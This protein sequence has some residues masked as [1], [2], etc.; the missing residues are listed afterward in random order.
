MTDTDTPSLS[1]SQGKGARTKPVWSTIAYYEVTIAPS[2]PVPHMHP[3]VPVCIS[4]LTLSMSIP[5]LQVTI[6]PPVPP[7]LSEATTTTE[8][9]FSSVTVLN[10]NSNSHSN[11]T[12][13]HTASQ[14]HAVEP[15][16]A[17]GLALPVT[18]THTPLD[19][20]T[21]LALLLPSSDTSY[22]LL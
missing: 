2:H 3:L 12:Y 21:I 19:P 6:H 17:V 15:C 14:S 1:S 18:H 8:G 5:S 20:L 13:T 10:S 16:V 7:V 4:I 9:G 11:T 22:H